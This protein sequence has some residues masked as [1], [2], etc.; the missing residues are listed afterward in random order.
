MRLVNRGLECVVGVTNL[1]KTLVPFTH[2]IENADCFS[3][4]RRRNFH[5]L[6][7]TF[8]RSILFDRL[9]KLSGSRRADALNLAAR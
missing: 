5:C 3:F 4:R 1:V 9:A 6:K 7:T 2:A 8:E